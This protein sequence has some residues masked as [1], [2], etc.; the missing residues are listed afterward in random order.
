MIWVQASSDLP[1]SSVSTSVQMAHHPEDAHQ[2]LGGQWHQWP[3][4]Q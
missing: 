3:G 1:A 4:R 2:E